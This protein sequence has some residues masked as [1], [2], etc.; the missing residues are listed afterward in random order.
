MCKG[1]GIGMRGTLWDGGD[2]YVSVLM[3]MID[4][5]V[6]SFECVWNFTQ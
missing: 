1:Q 5:F 3:H 6:S 2:N 4:G